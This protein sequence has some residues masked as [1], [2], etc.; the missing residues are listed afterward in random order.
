MTSGGWANTP[1]TDQTDTQGDT[2]IN[3][4]CDDEIG[5]LA[6]RIAA[7]TDPEP[8]VVLTGPA[9]D[10]REIRVYEGVALGPTD[11]DPIRRGFLWVAAVGPIRTYPSRRNT[12][13]AVVPGQIIGPHVATSIVSAQDAFDQAVEKL[14]GGC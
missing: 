2:M 10:G 4:L 7:D 13:G 5:A 8:V 12:E 14:A 11:H 3:H 1:V 9:A 6:R